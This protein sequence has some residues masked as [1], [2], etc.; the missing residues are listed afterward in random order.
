MKNVDINLLKLKA[1]AARQVGKPGNSHEALAEYYYYSG[2]VVRALEQVKIALQQP[3]ISKI[4][5]ARLE[6]NVSDLGPVVKRILKK[7]RKS[8]RASSPLSPKLVK[9]VAP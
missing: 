2:D 4:M 1:E 9:S 7:Q 8:N 5:R 3:N 6:Q